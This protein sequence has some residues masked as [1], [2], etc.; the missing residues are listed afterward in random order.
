RP[1]TQG[2]LEQ[3]G[4]RKR[5]ELDDALIGRKR[6]VARFGISEYLLHAMAQDEEPEH[7]P[8]DALEI[9]RPLLHGSYLPGAANTFLYSAA[10]VA[11]GIISM[12]SVFGGMSL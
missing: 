3:H 7:D 1:G 12:R 6:G 9:R 8:G 10:S 2:K 11:D 4:R 5:D